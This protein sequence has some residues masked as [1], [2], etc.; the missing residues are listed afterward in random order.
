VYIKL[1]NNIPE[2]YTVDRLRRDNPQVSFPQAIPDDTLAEYDVFPLKPVPVPTY[3]A[4]TQRVDAASPIY[5][6]RG[7]VQAW[8]VSELSQE[9][10]DLRYAARVE[11]V[12][13]Q[14]AEAYRQESDPLF[15]KAQR[16]EATHQEWL[17]K[18]AEIQARFPV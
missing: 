12:R 4:N 16:G 3:D 7:W 8:V 17:D 15:F 14:R 13:Q 1:T 5:D 18:V 10:I 9:E 11:R 2:T 6:A